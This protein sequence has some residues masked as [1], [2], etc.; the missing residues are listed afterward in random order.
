MHILHN[1]SNY[2]L[3]VSN[4]CVALDKITILHEILYKKRIF[5]IKKK[6]HNIIPMNIFYSIIKIILIIIIIIL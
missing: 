3:A 4:V 6:N 5:Y 1:L 2:R